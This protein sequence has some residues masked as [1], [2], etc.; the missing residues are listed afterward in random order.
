GAL[1]ADVDDVRAHGGEGDAA[2]DR[3]GGVVAGAVA[4]EGVGGGVHDP[5]H[6]GA[7]VEAEHVPAGGHGGGPRA[8][9]GEGGLEGGAEHLGAASPLHQPSGQVAEGAERAQQ[10]RP[11][12]G[13]GGER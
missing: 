9:P 4:A 13:G 11:V 5:H 6:Q 7:R 10:H 1:A 8:A 12:A 2:G 3:D